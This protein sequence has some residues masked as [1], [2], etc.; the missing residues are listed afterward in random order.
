[1]GL[2]DKQQPMAQKS[3]AGESL[4]LCSAFLAGEDAA[5]AAVLDDGS[6][7]HV[8]GRSGLAGEYQGR[9]AILGLRRRMVEL[10]E[11]TL[12]FS[13]PKVITGDDPAIFLLTRAHASREGKR[14]D[15]DVMHVVT[16][17]DCRLREMW[18]FHPN[19][20]HVDGFWS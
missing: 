1:M 13:P 7:L 8:P 20:C 14:L 6:L 2:V 3:D 16:S 4:A 12:R 9:E 19:Q 15:T 11:G 10:T 18:I 17:R 5:A